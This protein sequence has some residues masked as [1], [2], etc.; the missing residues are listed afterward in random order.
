MQ[1]MVLMG[2]MGQVDQLTIGILLIVHEEYDD[3]F[4]LN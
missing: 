2:K 1:K 4:G 3:G